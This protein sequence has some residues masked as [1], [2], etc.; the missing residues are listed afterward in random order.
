[1]EK[2]ANIRFSIQS[3]IVETIGLSARRNAIVLCASSASFPSPQKDQADRQRPSIII[4]W[5]IGSL[6]LLAR[7]ISGQVGTPSLQDKLAASLDSTRSSL[8]FTRCLSSASR[9][10]SASFATARVDLYDGRNRAPLPVFGLVI[11]CYRQ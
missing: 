7:I 10:S 9:P 8:K 6:A 2:R 1:L 11:T 3:R 5:F 4:V